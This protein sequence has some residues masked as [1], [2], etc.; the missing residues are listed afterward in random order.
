MLSSNSDS[1]R[2]LY[3]TFYCT[4]NS[5]GAQCQGRAVDLQCLD[6]CHRQCEDFVEPEP[7][8]ESRQSFVV[9]GS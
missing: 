2:L 4:F 5:R 9:R 6:Q 3:I 1:A 7:N 8:V